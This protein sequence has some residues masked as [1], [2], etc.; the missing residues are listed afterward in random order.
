MMKVFLK[1]LSVLAFLLVGCF[2]LSGCISHWFEDSTTRL[3]IE[4][5]TGADIIEID[6]IS[7]DGRLVRP[8]IQDTIKDSSVSRV[9]EEDWVG[10]FRGQIL[11][12]DSRVEKGYFDIS[13]SGGSLYLVFTRNPD[14]TLHF[15]SR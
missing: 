12:L 7:E 15:E 3:Q 13:L 5:R 1:H 14:G 9:Y 6:I 2:A 4:N 10:D 8:W 11:Y